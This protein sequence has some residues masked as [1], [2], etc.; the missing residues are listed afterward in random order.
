MSGAE[1][2]I[3]VR[4]AIVIVELDNGEHQQWILNPPVEV[5]IATDTEYETDPFSL[6]YLSTQTTYI[7]ALVTDSVHGRIQ[8]PT[9]TAEQVGPA[10]LE[11][12]K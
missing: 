10:E 5:T 7:F 6:R 3:Q 1:F 2:G 4:S 12:S 11:E 9:A 8:E